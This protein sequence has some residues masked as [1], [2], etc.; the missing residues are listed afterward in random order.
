MKCTAAVFFST[1]LAQRLKP[2]TDGGGFP[3]MVSL[4]VTSCMLHAAAKA[5]DYLAV[6]SNCL[7]TA[8]SSGCS[9]LHPAA[10]AALR[11]VA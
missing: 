2:L 9:E 10:F 11:W 4:Q 7:K 5:L 3:V 1:R 6:K 8:P